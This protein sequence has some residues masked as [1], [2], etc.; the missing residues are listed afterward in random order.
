MKN[1]HFIILLV[2]ALLTHA[3]F[4]TG[5]NALTPS[6]NA[7]EIGF[8]EGMGRASGSLT[9]IFA[10]NG[11]GAG[12]MFDIEPDIFLTEIMALD[13][14]WSEV[15]ESIDV[16]VYYKE[17]TSVGF[18]TDPT[19]WPLLAVGTGIGAGWDNPAFV[20]LS[21]NGVHFEA[22]TV[23]GLYVHVENY[24]DLNGYLARTMADR[25]PI[26]TAS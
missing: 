11:G 2:C 15:G 13:V 24:P 9:T 8:S 22:D 3:V 23:Y 17:G 14:N 25:T 7:D 18:E 4:G 16:H 12:N 10:A 19:P 21:G 6:S 1:C 5:V 26:P 20:D